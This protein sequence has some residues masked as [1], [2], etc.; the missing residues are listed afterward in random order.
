M[1]PAY[2]CQVVENWSAG[3]PGFGGL[4][5]EPDEEGSKAM[6]AAKVRGACSAGNGLH[7]LP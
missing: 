7:S 4:V 5:K 6:C 2:C 3:R 1:G